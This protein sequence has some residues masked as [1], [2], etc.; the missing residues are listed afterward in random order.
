MK[1]I[2]HSKPTN[3]PVLLR[4]NYYAKVRAKIFQKDSASK[5]SAQISQQYFLMKIL[6]QNTAT[7]KFLVK[8]NF[9]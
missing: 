6:Q 9:L 7:S 1:A 2:F 5:I 8:N 4:N 3:I